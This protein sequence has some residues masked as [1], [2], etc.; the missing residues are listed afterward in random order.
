M[1]PLAGRSGRDKEIFLGTAQEPESLG[2]SST[3]A[4]RAWLGLRGSA[5]AFCNH[6]LDNFTPGTLDWQLSFLPYPYPMRRR[7]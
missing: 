1:C 3:D 5:A 4:N 7:G 2:P 6:K